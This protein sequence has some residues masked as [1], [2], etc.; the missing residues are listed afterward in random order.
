MFFLFT[1]LFFLSRLLIFKV[2]KSLLI[3]MKLFNL[4][5]I[6]SLSII[7]GVNNAIVCVDAKIAKELNKKNKMHFLE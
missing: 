1:M 7:D 3:N 5:E 2:N 4:I 6:Y